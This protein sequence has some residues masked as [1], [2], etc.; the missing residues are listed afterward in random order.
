MFLI[1][2]CG[3]MFLALASAMRFLTMRST[4]SA[5]MPN[6]LGAAMQSIL[7]NKE[8]RLA[9]DFEITNDEKLVFVDQVQRRFAFAGLTGAHRRELPGDVKGVAIVDALILADGNALG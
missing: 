9:P 6:C 4:V 8:T 1:T 3:S 7:V 5:E 2:L